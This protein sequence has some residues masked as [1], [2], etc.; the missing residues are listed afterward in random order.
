MTVLVSIHGITAG[1]LLARSGVVPLP[2]VPRYTNPGG[3]GDRTGDSFIVEVTTN[4]SMLTAQDFMNLFN[5][6]EGSNVKLSTTNPANRQVTFDFG[7]GAKKVLNEITW[8]QTTTDTH[9]VW[10]IQGSND[11]KTWTNIGST[12][13][14]GGELSQVITT[15]AANTTSYRAY[16]MQQTSGTV[17]GTPDLSQILLKLAEDG[18]E[19]ARSSFA[20]WLGGGDR[21][22]DITVS[23]SAGLFVNP[24]DVPLLVGGG[25]IYFAPGK[26]D[27]IITFG[28]PE[29]VAFD[30]VNIG[31]TVAGGT[32]GT[33]KV[34]GSVTGSTWEDLSS[35]FTLGGASGTTQT[36]SL[37]G[38]TKAFIAYR[39]FQTGG[40]TASNPWLARIRF[41]TY[42]PKSVLRTTPL[43]RIGADVAQLNKYTVHRL[44]YSMV[45]QLNKY[46]VF[47]K[48]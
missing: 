32:H 27:G 33:W 23:A 5:G 28:L 26:T 30:V 12:F 43:S 44:R 47:R 38:N 10:Q 22:T 37:N 17:T 11:V 4:I 8:K 35:V 29:L 41:S 19:I 9:G 15:I 42:P 7:V 25:G 46:V 18:G 39:L 6:F 24:G 16:R 34:Q 20:N 13:T 36:V 48:L 31:Y 1:S 21:R 3:K 14:L 40:G 2:T 45:S